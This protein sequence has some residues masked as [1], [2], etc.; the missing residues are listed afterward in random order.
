VEM[1]NPAASCTV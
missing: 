1:K